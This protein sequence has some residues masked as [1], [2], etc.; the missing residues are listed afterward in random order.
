MSVLNKD[1]NL[2]PD[3]AKQAAI[4]LIRTTQHTFGMMTH[5]FNE[6]SRKFWS[7]P[8][9]A[10]PQQIADEL[11]TDAAE[12]FQLH[13]KLGTL[14]AEVDPT[15]VTEGLSIVGNFTMNEDG[16]VTVTE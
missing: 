9:G 12:V 4:D 11:G 10:T 7:N 14:L 5:A 3:P 2:R 16:T 15:S 1:V 8:D 13:S 6:G